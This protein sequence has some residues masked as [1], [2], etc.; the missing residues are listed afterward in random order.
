MNFK[1]I[2]SPDF[3]RILPVCTTLLFS[4]IL[5]FL[6]FVS[7]AQTRP[8]ESDKIT[9]PN[10]WRLSP[11]GSQIPLGDLPLNIA[12]TR[13]FKYAAVTNNGQS[14][15]SV[16]LIRIRDQKLV[17]SYE[18]GKSWLGLVFSDDGK[19][20]YVSGGNDNW[21]LQFGIKNEKLVCRDTFKL[22]KTWPEKFPLPGSL[23]M[24]HGN[25]Y[26]L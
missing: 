10:G 5:L 26:M 15:Q 22:G 21:I 11:A 24:K 12:V 7:Q 8:G 6:A 19:N 16:Q 2:T 4:G 25:A 20:L 9:L 23:S 14:T 3:Q 13:N 1:P 18:V 17:D